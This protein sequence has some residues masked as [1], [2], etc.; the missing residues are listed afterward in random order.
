MFFSPFFLLDPSVKYEMGS[1][2][3]LF[4]LSVPGSVSFTGENKSS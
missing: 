1:L 2:L 3:T 4:D